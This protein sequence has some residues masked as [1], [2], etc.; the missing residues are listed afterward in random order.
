MEI[1]FTIFYTAVMTYVC[2]K[3]TEHIPSD[4]KNK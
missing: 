3:V 4:K 1:L 2:T